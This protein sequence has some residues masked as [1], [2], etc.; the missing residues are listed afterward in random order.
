MIIP[1]IIV[2]I[3]L[4]FFINNGIVQWSKFGNLILDVGFFEGSRSLQVL[5]KVLVFVELNSLNFNQNYK[6][7]KKCKF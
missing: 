1:I 7:Q 2:R 5:V 6:F 3:K 4:L